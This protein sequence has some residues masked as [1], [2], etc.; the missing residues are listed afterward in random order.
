M[1]PVSQGQPQP[2]AAV[3]R[4]LTDRAITGCQQLHASDKA[5]T[6]AGTWRGQQVV[7]K[8]RLGDDSYWAARQRNERRVYAALGEGIPGLR[9]ARIL[10]TDDR[11]IILE[12]LAGTPA[13]TGRYPEDVTP[14]GAAAVMASL[15]NLHLWRPAGRN[16]DEFARTRVDIH[17]AMANEGMTDRDIHA[18]DI[19]LARCAALR[20]EHGDPLPSNFLID[21]GQAAPVDFEHAGWHLPGTDWALMT[22]LWAPGQLALRPQVQAAVDRDRVHDGYAVALMAYACHELALHRTF[23]EQAPAGRRA[24]LQANLAHARDVLHDSL[25]RPAS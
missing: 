15:A 25:D 20:I 24:V 10:H 17:R 11:M 23:G 1:F 4:L 7:V 2:P 21:G 13:G 18:V 12:W 19:L 9:T 6:V 22:L 8:V 16:V 5:V 3:A 14:A